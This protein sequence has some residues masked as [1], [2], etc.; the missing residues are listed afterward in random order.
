M[1]G[2]FTLRKPKAHPWLEVDAEGDDDLSFPRCNIAPSQRVPV[3]GRRPNG[4]RVARVAT[5]GF[6][7]RWYPADRKPPINVRAETVADKPLFRDPG[8]R[9]WLVRMAGARERPETTV[10]LPPPR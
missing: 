5:W 8:A 9:R 10:F 1:C 6:L 2:R 7:P 3:V 4:E